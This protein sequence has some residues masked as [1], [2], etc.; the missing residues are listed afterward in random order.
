VS[1]LLP[2]VTHVGDWKW[3]D[4]PALW[5]LTVVAV[6]LFLV[7]RALYRRERGRA[8]RSTRLFLAL[9]RTA[10]LF[11]LLLLLARPFREEVTVAQERS[12]LVVL[13]DASASMETSDTY[14]PEESRRLVEALWPAGAAPGGDGPLEVKRIDLV[15]RA[16]AGDD[17]ALLAELDRRFVLHVYAFDQEWRSLGV[18]RRESAGAPDPAAEAEEADRLPR[19]ARAIA[20]LPAQGRSTNLGLVLRSVA[21]DYLGREDRRLAG[22]LLV[23]DGRDTS[24]GSNPVEALTDL[25]ALRRELH[26][27]AVALGNPATGRN[28]RLERIRAPDV[29]LVGD[30]VVIESALRHEGFV[31]LE[32]VR[33]QMLVERVRDAEGRDLAPDPGRRAQP[34]EA[35]PFR[36]GAA[37]E[38]VPVHYQ[39]PFHEAGTFKLTLRAVLPEPEAREDAQP[40]DDVREHWI[41]VKDQRIRVLFVDDQPR[42]DWRFLSNYLTR[43]PDAVPGRPDVRRRYEAHVLQLTRDPTV[44]QPASPGLPPLKAFPST[45]RDLFEY[46]VLLWGDVDPRRLADTAEQARDIAA[47]VRDFVAEGGGIGFQAGEGYNNPGDFRDTPLL[48]LLPINLRSRDEGASAEKKV[49]FR[50]GLTDVGMNHPIFDVLPGRDGRPLTPEERGL[51]WGGHPDWPL[52]RAWRW[53]W[54]YRATGGLRPGAVDLARVRMEGGPPPESFLDDADRPLVLFAAMG[55]GKGRVLWTALDALSVLRH[56]QSDRIY[57]PFWDRTIRW[58]AT[59]RLLGGNARFKISTD[60]ESYFVGETATV[61]ITA[62]DRD[63]EPLLDPF[64]DGVHVED[65]LGQDASLEGDARP[66]SLVPDGA[67]PGTYQVDVAVRSEGT[68]R[69]WISDTTSAGGRGAEDRAEGRFEA[70]YRRPELR[71]TLPHHELLR[72]IV[73]ETDGLLV[74]GR[75]ARVYDLPALARVLPARTVER[76]LDREEKAQ[77]DRPWVLLLLVGLLAL[78]W[79]LRKRNH[80]V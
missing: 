77:W 13:I 52:S 58:L 1:P 48:D 14:D 17:L 72:Q 74:D 29:V 49:A 68:W 22:V 20:D 79:A 43:E 70:D 63:Y 56:G 10:V 7:A 75:L 61:T 15:R 55:Y 16:L 62:L 5:V 47:L 59:Y 24:E 46:D 45:R 64:L 39:V 11:L 6:G 57:G 41:R 54:L 42:Y 36:L 53:H 69:I 18:G 3:A 76:V 44:E 65:P 73:E 12:D 38:P 26:V 50:I 66:R 31:G 32:G 28:L 21:A 2:T 25:R 19:L 78:E 27:T 8:G 71:Q 37:D 80:M 9:V 4:L 23:S 30:D 51:V 60:K 33:T 67:A 40:D 34:L 35:G